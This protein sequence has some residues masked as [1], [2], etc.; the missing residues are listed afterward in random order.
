M[1][2]QEGLEKHTPHGIHREL[3]DSGSPGSVLRPT[4]SYLWQTDE[5]HTF[6]PTSPCLH[7]NADTACVGTSE[8]QTCQ[9][10]GLFVLWQTCT[11]CTQS[12]THTPPGVQL[13]PCCPGAST[14]SVRQEPYK[15]ETSVCLSVFS[16]WTIFC[17]MPP[18][19]GHIQHSAQYRWVSERLCIRKCPHNYHTVRLVCGEV[20][21]RA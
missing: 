3:A 16:L 13:R 18:L 21:S 2:T 5:T 4:E 9:H 20:F 8:T 6:T 1:T 17:L 7:A 10:Q 14:A 12:C 11:P 19:C 15:W